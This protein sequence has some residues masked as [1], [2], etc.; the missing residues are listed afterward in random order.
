[1]RT[2]RIGDVKILDLLFTKQGLAL[3]RFLV[4]WTGHSLIG[5]EFA[6]SIGMPEPESLLLCTTG[7]QTGRR[8]SAVLPYYRVGEDLVVV[9]SNGGGPTDPHWA[10]NVRAHPAASIRLD[11]KLRHVRARVADG[12]ERERIW[13][14]IT[15]GRGPYVRYQEMA[16]PRVLPV[17]VLSPE[18][19]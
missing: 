18:P 3:D 15:G 7:A 8:R 12:E 19:G 2:R 13:R 11:R 16:H 1:M 9:G 17:V 4:R 5:R 10:A 6:K 14:Q